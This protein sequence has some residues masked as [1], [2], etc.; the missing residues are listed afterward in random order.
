MPW[1]TSAQ[2]KNLKLEVSIPNEPW[3]YLYDMM[4]EEWIFIGRPISPCFVEKEFN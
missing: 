3:C 4:S 1:L 2:V